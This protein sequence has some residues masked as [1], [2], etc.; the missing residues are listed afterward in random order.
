MTG[1][2]EAAMDDST[3]KM[4]AEAYDETVAE[5]MAQGRAGEVAHR[6]GVTA[7]AMFLSSLTGVEDA[8]A[9][10][11]VDQLGLEPT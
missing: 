8:A 5:A 9:R 3:R 11:A 6:E 4:V 1:T 2:V 10:S 7:A